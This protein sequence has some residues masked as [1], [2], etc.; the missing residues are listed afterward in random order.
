VVLAYEL[1]EVPPVAS[2]FCQQLMHCSC[3]NP[4]TTAGL[5]R[6]AFEELV[7]GFA[8]SSSQDG[9]VSEFCKIRIRRYKKAYICELNGFIKGNDYAF[10]LDSESL[11]CKSNRKHRNVIK[12]V[13]SLFA[14]YTNILPQLSSVIECKMLKRSQM[15]EVASMQHLLLQPL[16]CGTN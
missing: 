15:L 16:S 1:A 3:G 5:I 13:V 8:G 12:Q 11:A 10:L 7:S 14:M 9:Q 6:S 4:Q 2:M